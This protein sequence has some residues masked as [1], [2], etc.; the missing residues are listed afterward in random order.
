MPRVVHFEI[1]A[2]NPEKVIAFYTELF[3]WTINSWGGP[4]EYWMI[5]TGEGG[6]HGIDGGLLRRR[7]PAPQDGQCVNAYVCTIDVPDVDAFQKK[8]ESL[9]AAVVVPKMTIPG[10][11][12]LV[13]CKD[14]DGNI[15]GM[16]Q[17]SP[18]AA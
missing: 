12:W 5:Q 14:T 6:A 16:M 13:Y 17:M 4:S 18:A 10:I 11:G 15:F 3:G 1:H 7:G 8:A 9:G 2:T